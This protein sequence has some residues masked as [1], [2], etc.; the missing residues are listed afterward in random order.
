MLGWKV[1]LHHW[2]TNKSTAMINMHN[3]FIDARRLPTTHEHG[4]NVKLH[5]IQE[6][7]PCIEFH[8]RTFE[9]PRKLPLAMYPKERL[10]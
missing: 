5:E 7:H 1:V 3:S 9:D 2:K 6:Y 8:H 4:L 10:L